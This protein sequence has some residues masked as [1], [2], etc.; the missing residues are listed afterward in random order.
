MDPCTVLY[1]Y[2]LYSAVQY[3]VPVLLC[4]TEENEEFLK[5][6]PDTVYSTVVCRIQSRNV[7]IEYSCAP[8]RAVGANSRSLEGL[9]ATVIRVQFVQYCTVHAT[10]QTAAYNIVEFSSQK[11][12]GVLNAVGYGLGRHRIAK[13]KIKTEAK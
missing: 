11:S 9:M 5:G 13:S 3:A 7:P 8:T 12:A 2:S 4:S 10:H 1:Q 6:L